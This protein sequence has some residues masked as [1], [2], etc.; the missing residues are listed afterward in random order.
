M[1]NSFGAG[2][3]GG[4]GG[5]GTVTISGG[6]VAVKANNSGAGIGG[7]CN[8]F[9]TVEIKGGTVTATASNAGTAIG[10]G[11]RGS[12]GKVTFEGGSVS[13]VNMMPGKPSLG[14]SDCKVS[15]GWT[16]DGKKNYLNSYVYAAGYFAGGDTV[17]LTAHFRDAGTA[18]RF[19]QEEEVPAI[20][21][22]AALARK[23][24]IPNTPEAAGQY[25]WSGATFSL[26]GSLGEIGKGA[27]QNIR[28]ATVLVPV[29]V[30]KIGPD[31][32]RGSGVK[33]IKFENGNPETFDASAFE[34]C[35]FVIVY[36]TEKGSVY[37]TLKDKAN[38][39][40]ISR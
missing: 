6:T 13:A 18:E 37:E 39:Y 1:A 9:G 14:G 25:A 24:L 26:P 32:F 22:S 27:F 11:E 16:A 8:S 28:A 34:G 29:G 3:G 23:L 38:V 21:G 36:T 7:G 15:L 10:N 30:K 19:P 5:A 4:V 33:R 35:P 40:I 17:T 31:A 12:G 2:T 20:I